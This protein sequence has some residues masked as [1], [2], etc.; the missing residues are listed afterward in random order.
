MVLEVHD[1]IAGEKSE[2][3]RG[4]RADSAGHVPPSFRNLGDNVREMSIARMPEPD[5]FRPS[6]PLMI[7]RVHPV[8]LFVTRKLERR[9]LLRP[10][11]PL[12]VV[13]RGVDEM[14]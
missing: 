1:V 9:R 13:R 14:P 8:I 12:V 3:D 2:R 7:L 10:H 4:V 6:A 11:E 5:E